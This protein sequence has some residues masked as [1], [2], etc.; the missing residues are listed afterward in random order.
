MPK[1][2]GTEIVVEE[3]T[4][5]EFERMSEIGTKVNYEELW[6]QVAGKILSNRGLSKI[7]S[8]LRADG[9]ERDW[10]YSEKKRVFN[11]WRE[12]GRVIEEKIGFVNNRRMKFYKFIVP[13]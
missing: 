1:K 6:N 12:K 4:E 11:N 10:Y 5:E 9:K 8:A 13:E 2:T 7:V 3:I